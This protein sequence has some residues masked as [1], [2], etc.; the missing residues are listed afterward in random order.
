MALV[1]VGLR[2][3][4]LGVALDVR[5][6]RLAD[7]GLLVGLEQEGLVLTLDRALDQV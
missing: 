4:D 1:A 3:G 7:D 5:E 2:A 6:Q